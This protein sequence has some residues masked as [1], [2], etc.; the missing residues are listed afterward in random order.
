MKTFR[1]VREGQTETVIERSRF[2]AFTQTVS[3][4]AEAEAFL[5]GLRSRYRDATHV[6]YGYVADETGSV[7]RFSDDGEPSG[8]AG[9]PILEVVK[10]NG[11][12]RSLVAVVRYFGG[13]KLGAGGLTRAYAGCAAKGVAAAGRDE[14]A[15]MDAAAV[16]AAFS[17]YDKI[18][19]NLAQSLCK[20]TEI[21]YN[22]CVKF[23]LCGPK[24]IFGKLTEWTAGRV[25]IVPKGERCV[26]L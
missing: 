18:S 7:Q 13:I 26:K 17:D 3:S 11:L 21:E 22:E 14:Y 2:I 10:S 9:M 24:E 23:T 4:E 1:A 6:C 16:T 20:I 12:K 5:A 8:T 19:K 15:Y 25:E